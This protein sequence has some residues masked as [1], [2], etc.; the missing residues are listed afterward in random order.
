[1]RASRD[2]GGRR[3][4]S[5]RAS[6][7]LLSGAMRW[8][9]LVLGAIA[10]IAAVPCRAGVVATWLFDEP[11]QA[12][13]STIL[14]D[15]G[16][17]GFI[18]ALGRGARLAEGR[19]GNAL[20]PAEPEPLE[21]HGTAIDPDSESARE[22]GLVPLAP[23]AGRSVQPMWWPTATFAALMTSGEKH[24]RSPGFANATDAKLNL[25]PFDW[26]LELWFLPGPGEDGGVLYEIGE[27][28]RGEND[29]V[30]RLSL[31]P[32]RDH[33]E[34]ANP[35]SGA[36]VSIPT[37]AAA[38]HEGSPWRHLAFVYAS[39]DGQ[40]RHYVDGRVQPL[41]ARARL[42]AL[43][44]GDE[45]YLSI[46][47]DGRFEHALPG[48]VDE[49]RLSDTIVYR[50]DFEPPGSF[51]ARAPGRVPET[52]H[53]AGPPL[54]FGPLAP[55]A[56]VKELGSR[57]YL[58][59]DDALIAERKGV[60]FEVNPPR[61]MEKVAD[62]VRGHL[63][64]LEDD[65]GLI[66]VY[67]QGPDDEL[68]LLTS[69][70][71]IHFDRPDVGHGEH[72]GLRNI[73]LPKPVGRGTVLFDPEAPPSR[74]FV[75]L[76]GLRRQGIFVFTSPDGLWFE[77]SDTAALPFS[78]GSQSALYYDD[79]RQLYVAHH[80]SD[81]G[82]TP[83][84]ATRR[85]F[86]LSEVKELDGP[87][88][89]ER[90]TPE[91]TQEIG[92]RE[93]IQSSVLDPWFLDNGP[94]APSGFGVELPTVFA[95]DP[96]LDPVGTDVYVTK[97]LKYP[98]APDSYLA[99]PAMYF[100]YEGDGPETRQI[101]GRPE[102]NR[103][104]GVIETQLAVSRD[105]V[106]WTHRPRPAYVSIGGDGSNRE[107]MLFVAQGMVRRGDE[108]W[109]YVGGHGGGGTAYHSR[110]GGQ[111]PAPLYHY[112]QRLDGFVAAVS[113][114]TGGTMKS[115]PLRFQGN[116]LLLNVDTGA[117]GFLQV[118]FEDEHGRPIPGYSVDDCI[119][120]NGDFLRTPVEW[121]GK[122]HDVSELEGRVVQLVF[123]MRGAR[124]YAL[125]FLRE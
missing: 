122:G 25:G 56:K 87:W 69:R 27:G 99:F 28:P 43:P 42:A 1:M 115:K 66:R 95:A 29:R 120:L 8:W 30:A 118:G 22:F 5:F 81:Y 34:L 3:G 15:A 74:R 31:A 67:Y 19:F 103:G 62:E 7:R 88:P 72:H 76:S 16:P 14:N 65:R 104:S 21:M 49:L 108:I 6:R 82:A 90:I 11:V 106:D 94:L 91:R 83:G 92:K 54:L 93:A 60:E 52:R 75:Y 51:S 41:P 46:G 12:Y 125:Q 117:V 4:R 114:Y 44:H 39:A 17:N 45:A 23:A 37:D 53:H 116:R 20:E 18:L 119:Y 64:V 96:R 73:V 71:G 78:A 84:G 121:L 50:A 26:T 105:G 113:E 98:W 85:R 38:L 47:R 107:H 68:A 63:S 55:R 123:R 24:L 101:L 32:G 100:H 79:Q 58:F 86:V 111:N 35:P 77:Q 9:G 97:A 124:L 89:F 48:R 57:K 59:L 13:P 109:Q 102:R 112:V 33:F 10:W 70:D 110:H 61:R 40:L 2:P 36:V 80:R